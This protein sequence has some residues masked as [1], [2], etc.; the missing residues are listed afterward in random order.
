MTMKTHNIVSPG[1]K[2]KASDIN[3]LPKH[4]LNNIRAGEGI[5]LKRSN[6][7]L[8]ISAIAAPNRPGGSGGLVIEEVL[9]LPVLNEANQKYIDGWIVYW[10]SEAEEEGATGDSQLWMV[11]FPQRQWYP[12]QRFT[13]KSGVPISEP[14]G[15]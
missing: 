12:L 10:L 13:A 1:E 3:G 7:N 14:E 6:N 11:R 8:I 4:I 9:D 2:I 15:S 5:S